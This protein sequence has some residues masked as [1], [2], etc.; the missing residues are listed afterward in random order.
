MLFFL[1]IINF[2]ST[3]STLRHENIAFFHML[4]CKCFKIMLTIYISPGT[5]S[6][7]N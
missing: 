7:F 5:M 3:Q 1:V 2:T 4:S 6:N